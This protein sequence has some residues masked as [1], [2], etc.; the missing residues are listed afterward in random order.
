MIARANIVIAMLVGYLR[1]NRE[2]IGAAP[3]R[4]VK[5]SQLVI[6][7]ELEDQSRDVEAYEYILGETLVANERRWTKRRCR[8]IAR[9]HRDS[10]IWKSK[11]TWMLES[12]ALNRYFD[13]LKESDVNTAKEMLTPYDIQY[14]LARVENPKSTV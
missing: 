6:G 14:E 10:A 9:R 2:R 7:S 11:D 4:L 5:D 3:E 13:S 8:T 12:R 1:K